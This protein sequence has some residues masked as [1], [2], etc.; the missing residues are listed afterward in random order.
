[1]EPE[2]EEVRGK[3]VGG[4]DKRLTDQRLVFSP[5]GGLSHLYFRRDGEAWRGDTSSPT[6]QKILEV[7]QALFEANEGSADGNVRGAMA[8]I[9]VKTDEN[10]GT[11]NFLDGYQVLKRVDGPLRVR[12]LSAIEEPWPEIVS[13]I[14]NLNDKTAKGSN[15]GDIVVIWKTAEG[16]SSEYG[17]NHGSHGGVTQA[18]VEVP[19]I[20]SSVLM[21]RSVVADPNDPQA[22]ERAN[23]NIGFIQTARDAVRNQQARAVP[24]NSDLTP[25]LLEALR[26]A[27]GG[28]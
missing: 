11:N 23:H 28:N 22:S 9:L 6:N 15:S 20:F 7:A 27:K 16:Y 8:V 1:V 26:A 18:E 17:K 19:L 10:D 5:N 4:L 12:A 13:R 21:Q 2:D 14:D 24:S 25:I 3:G